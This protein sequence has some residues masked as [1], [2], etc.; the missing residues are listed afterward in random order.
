M[1]RRLLLLLL[2]RLRL[3]LPLPLPLPLPLRGVA[4]RNIER[5]IMQQK[6][7]LPHLFTFC[8]CLFVSIG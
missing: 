6:E 2:L 5:A 1:L 3:R 8:L 4:S 7:A